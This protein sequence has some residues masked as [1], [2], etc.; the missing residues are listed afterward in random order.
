ML[1]VDDVMTRD[2]LTL[3]GNVTAEEAAARLRVHGITGAPV[4]DAQGRV[5]GVLSLTDLTDPE[6]ARAGRP[7]RELMTPALFSL[8]PTDALMSA[9]R[10]MVRQGVHRI[11]VTDEQGD[12]VGIVTTGDVLRALDESS[13]T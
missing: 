8:R 10:L 5:I 6:R 3:P 1:T 7:V 11:L 13:E 9:V 12:L 2:V 4:V